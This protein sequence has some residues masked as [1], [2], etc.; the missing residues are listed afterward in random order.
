M[1]M[2][3]K[4]DEEMGPIDHLRVAWPGR[5]P[6]GKVTHPTD[7]IDQGPIRILDRASIVTDEDGNVTFLDVEGV[8]DEVVEL[9][10]FEGVGSRLPD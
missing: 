4:G 8:A 2:D 1:G 3:A 5:L 9:A 6:D 7:P 10:V